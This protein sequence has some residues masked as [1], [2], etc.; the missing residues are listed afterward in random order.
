MKMFVPR[1]GDVVTGDCRGD[2][3]GEPGRRAI[4]PD[5]R[6]Y[7]RDHAP[8]LAALAIAFIPVG[9]MGQAAD[10]KYIAVDL[11]VPQGGANSSAL[12]VNA[13]GTAVVG[14]AR[15]GTK[16]LPF[17]WRNGQMEVIG[18]SESMTAEPPAA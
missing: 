5:R 4:A 13:D 6:A 15:V 2:E 11:G 1:L 17:V 9:A 8:L 3:D 16:N 7:A 12:A 10:P 18:D 14:Q